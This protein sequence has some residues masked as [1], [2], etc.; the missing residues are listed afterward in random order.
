MITLQSIHHQT[1]DNNTLDGFILL[2]MQGYEIDAIWAT[3]NP[4]QN[5]L[6]ITY[7]CT[8]DEELSLKVFGK[9]R[10]RTL[11]VNHEVY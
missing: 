1:P 10:S 3:P 5:I 11:Y 7:T 9:S 2:V 8:G 6:S 4:V